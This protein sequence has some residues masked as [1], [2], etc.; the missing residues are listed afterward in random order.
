[1][2]KLALL[3]G[4]GALITSLLTAQNLPQGSTGA[5]A[6]IVKGEPKYTNGDQ[7]LP[8]KR[9]ATIPVGA[10]VTTGAGELVILRLSN[11]GKIVVYQNSEVTLQA[12]AGNASKLELHQPKGFTW[13]RLPKLKQEESFKVVT[14]S[15]SAGIRG[16][17]FSVDSLE[18]GETR[19]CVCEGAVHVEG[20]GKET[21][22]NQG[23]LVHAQPG[24]DLSPMSDL[25]FLEHPTAAHMSCIR[26]HKGGY[27]R[28]NL[29]R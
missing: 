7:V 20:N 11:G 6:R 16:T 19:V 9:G 1:M 18:N 3:F 8:V 12:E 17:A 29:Y 13:S 14:A 4:L 10:T 24:Q 2:K 26:C 5:V 25:K 21:T 27:S 23:Q 28:D 22:V 15:Y